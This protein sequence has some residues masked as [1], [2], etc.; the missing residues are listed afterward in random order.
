[1]LIGWNVVGAFGF[2]LT[3]AV[4]LVVAFIVAIRKG[5]L[6]TKAFHDARIADK[7]AELGR[8]DAELDRKE[9]EVVRTLADRDRQLER[10]DREH[11][12]Q[13][14][15]AEREI[16]DLRAAHQAQDETINLQAKQI[17][18]LGEIGRTL[19]AVLIA[20]GKKAVGK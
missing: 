6:I 8:K 10:A 20:V 13:M 5:N 16:R 3:A 11:R 18:Q 7:D 9:A 14:E 1:M 19:S 12:E 15:R 17:D 4:S 2:V